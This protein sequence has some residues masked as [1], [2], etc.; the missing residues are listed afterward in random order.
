MEI[1]L[2]LWHW[3]CIT[4]HRCWF[5]YL[6]E[7]SINVN[8]FL[9][10]NVFKTVYDVFKCGCRTTDEGK[11]ENLKICVI[12]NKV[13]T[14]VNM[15]FVLFLKSSPASKFDLR[16]MFLGIFPLRSFRVIN[17]KTQNKDTSEEYDFLKN[18]CFKDWDQ[19]SMLNWWTG[20]RFKN[21]KFH[22]VFLFFL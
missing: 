2:W 10:N 15:F 20:M 9:N 3:S 16:Y 12:K 14:N 18:I 8:I 7:I 22:V 11:G 21:P 17:C 13:W 19:W 6:Q 5:L 1:S 4:V